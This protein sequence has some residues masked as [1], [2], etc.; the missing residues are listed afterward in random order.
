MIRASI[1]VAIAFTACQ[2]PPPSS[3][4]PRTP[5]DVIAEPVPGER[6]SWV[7][8][9]ESF[10]ATRDGSKVV[11]EWVCSHLATPSPLP[12]ELEA[13][14]IHVSGAGSGFFLV[15]LVSEMPQEEIASLAVKTEESPHYMWAS[16]TV[17]SVVTRR[18][19][20]VVFLYTEEMKLGHDLVS[21][22]HP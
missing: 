22:S 13:P 11:L 7:G 15:N 14:P 8:E 6:V 18:G 12:R 9:I 16:G 1:V 21:F 20:Q 2:V 3:E 4:L 10:E 5:G 17:E 19:R